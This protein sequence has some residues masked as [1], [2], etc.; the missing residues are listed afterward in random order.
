MVPIL[1]D[2]SS[3]G[4]PEAGSFQNEDGLS[5]CRVAIELPSG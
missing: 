3:D 4:R 5:E 1:S 2:V